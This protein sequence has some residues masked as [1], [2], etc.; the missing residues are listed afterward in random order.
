MWMYKLQS[1]KESNLKT[2][3]LSY[4]CI[5]RDGA[6]TTDGPHEFV[7]CPTNNS[8]VPLNW[9]QLK[10]FAAL[11]NT[12]QSF[13]IDYLGMS[14]PLMRNVIS[15]MIDI[16][17][18]SIWRSDKIVLSSYC[19]TSLE[20]PRSCT[21]PCFVF[22]FLFVS[23]VGATSMPPCYYLAVLLLSAD[24]PSETRPTWTPWSRQHYGCLPVQKWA[25]WLD[26]GIRSLQAARRYHAK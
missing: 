16:A 17:S 10:F 20:K 22:L 24:P 9:D 13:C 26:S 3:A 23:H 4:S 18:F 2:S 1:E 8:F 21:F 7:F 12:N 19:A 25:G 15:A 11:K 6:S 5:P 14:V